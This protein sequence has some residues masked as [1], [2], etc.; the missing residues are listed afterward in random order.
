MANILVRLDYTTSGG[1]GGDVVG[2]A[3]ATNTAVA[4]FDGTTGKTLKNSVVT[5]D[6]SGNIVSPGEL[7]LNG[8]PVLST[9]EQIQDE[10]DPFV[11]TF[12]VADWGTSGGLYTLSVLAATH[13]KGVSPLVQ[14]FEED[15][16]KYI[17]VGIAV[18]I[19]S[20]N[21]NITLS[22]SQSP[23]LRFNGKIVIY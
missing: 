14:V 19:D 22:V 10:I 11:D 21:G 13:A 6:G 8:T 9:I 1:G 7:T 15:T 12:L 18:E 20:G 2:P 16:G 4:L 23:D 17:Q 3:S 5:I